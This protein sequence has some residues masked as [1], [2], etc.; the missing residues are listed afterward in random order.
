MTTT[1]QLAVALDFGVAE[2]VPVGRIARAPDESLLFQFAD[3]FLDTGLEISP[4]T[5]PALKRVQRLPKDRLW[6]V[7]ED[8]LP[9]TWGRRILSRR[10]RGIGD[11][12]DGPIDMLALVGRRAM[13]ALTY[14]PGLESG[15]VA[16]QHYSVDMLAQ[17]AEELYRG[18]PPQ[19]IEELERAAQSPGGARPK[20]V[21][22]I[23][24]AGR[25]YPDTGTLPVGVTPWLIKFHGDDPVTVGVVEAAFL[26]LAARAGIAVPESRVL[27]ASDGRRY[28]ATR[29]FD[30]V[31]GGGRLHMHTVGGLLGLDRN[32]VTDYA[33]LIGAAVQIAKDVGVG[34]Q[35]FRQMIFNIL[36]DNFDDHDKNFSM[37]MD[38]A[39]T[40]RLSPA[41]DLT[42]GRAGS[43]GHATLI[44][45]R[46]TDVKWA[47]CTAVARAIGLTS[48]EAD[49]ALQEV[50]AATE[51]W[52]DC[53][54]EVDLSPEVAGAIRRTIARRLTELRPLRP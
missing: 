10:L 45:G 53:A 12:R 33:E 18:E 6:S 32:A 2:P 30:R 52:L 3:E 41:Y 21:V 20:V 4:L 16:A 54:D 25:I 40:W 46:G 1:N 15:T 9:D 50:E 8:S 44:A 14:E 42:W 48:A 13:G 19:V 5:L 39:G 24:E 23:D 31:G 49:G 36:V 28:L 27:T 38:P 35:L 51:K 11:G 26:R 7:F 34:A 22:G 43:G 29:R 37:L 47:D 17:E